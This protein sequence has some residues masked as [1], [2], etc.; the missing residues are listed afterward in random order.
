MNFSSVDFHSKNLKGTN[1]KGTNLSN[2]NFSN[3]NLR[4]ANLSGANLRNVD[5]SAADLS[6][7]DLSN[8]DLSGANLNNAYLSNANLSGTNL[9]NRNLSNLNFNEAD[10][11]DA[12]L[13]GANLNNAILTKAKLCNVNFQRASFIDSKLD[14]ANLTGA[15]LWQIQHGGWSIKGLICQKAFWDREGEKLQK[16]GESAFERTFEEKSPILLRY[17]GAMDP[18]DFAMMPLIIERLQAEHPE[19]TIR[20][21]SIQDDG[22]GAVV[23]ITIDNESGYSDEVFLSEVD[24]LRDKLTTIQKCLQ[25]EKGFCQ[26]SGQLAESATS[27]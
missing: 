5:L 16:Y 22:T 3:T 9:S 6:G 4:C 14:G 21:R 27:G 13:S 7:A 25:H 18:V 8:A 1:F 26:I 15:K 2:S 11:S 19:N 10:L 17:P 12:D 20:I 24:K 23:T